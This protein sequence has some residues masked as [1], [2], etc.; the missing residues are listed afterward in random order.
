[1]KWFNLGGTKWFG[2]SLHYRGTA[3]CV[4]KALKGDKVGLEDE[5]RGYRGEICRRK[6][7]VRHVVDCSGC[8]QMLS[9]KTADVL[10]IT[11]LWRVDQCSVAVQ[12][13]HTRVCAWCNEELYPAEAE[14]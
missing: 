11:S 4:G 8:M 6:G 5:G 1:M 9:T 14:L 3:S 7:L 2:S 12:V 10:A 13:M